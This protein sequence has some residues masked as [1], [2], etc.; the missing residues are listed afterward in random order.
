MLFG[1]FLRN[2]LFAT[3]NR[4]EQIT[5]IY[6]FQ[7]VRSLPAIISVT[8]F[9]LFISSGC[10]Q[11]GEDRLSYSIPEQP[12]MGTGY[13]EKPGWA[14]NEFAVAAANP[15]AVDAGYQIIQAGGSA[16]DAA[17]AVQM[18]L[19]LVEPQSSGIG[20]GAFLLN[21]DGEQVHAYNGRERAPAAADENHFLDEDGE[22]MPFRD[23]VRSGLSVGVPGT[24]AMLKHAHERHGVLDWAVLFEPAITLAE[25][26]FKVSPRLHGLLDGEETLLNDDIAAKFYYDESGEARPIGYELKNPALA[27]IFSRIAAEGVDAF[28]EG[29]VAENIVKRIQAHERPGNMT[30]EDIRN[31]PVLDFTTEAMCNDWR[32]Y[33]ICGFPP[34]SSGH[35]AIMQML[36]IMEHL[37]APETSFENGM[38][39]AGWLHQYLEAAKLAFADRNK[40]IGDPDF[41]EAPAGDWH[42]LLD[43]GYLAKRAELI[44]DR[45]MESAEPGNPGELQ[46]MLGVQPLQPERGTSH[47][48]IVD[49]DGNAVS[50]TTTI[51]SGFGSRIMSDGGTGLP[52][53][54]LLNNELT[55]LS[56]TPIDGDGNP[57]A[58]R[59]E[60]YKRP[61]SSMSP[62]LVFDKE[63]GSL[64]ASVGSPGGAAIIHYTAKAIVGMLDW[65]LNAQDAIN[66][67]NFANYNGP[68][69]L[70]KDRFPEELI[71]ALRAL[72]HEISERNMTSGLQAI[73]VTEEGYYGGADPRREGVV[74]GN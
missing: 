72:G 6:M 52:G 70:E 69:V 28:Y 29:E 42:S 33:N 54:F 16:V 41:V 15:L 23:A 35:I 21:W 18:V 2:I 67:P 24:V 57:I 27:E 64:V 4:K 66:L 50:M 62:T 30:A 65:N 46:A 3:F 36:G 25:E 68:S 47:I 43:P 7:S 8:F 56:L 51:E 63:T 74:K 37:E 49:R 73:Q 20:G 10:E 11:T 12:E 22:P 39:T 45:S 53:G 58:N 19:T 1:T 44:G 60:P 13:T 14:V 38:L 5:S 9:A 26:G 61:R 31:Y 59:V 71:D 32:Q 40:Y 17:I 48:S 55:D 34:P